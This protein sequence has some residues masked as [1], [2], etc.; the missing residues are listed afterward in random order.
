ME[1]VKVTGR[2]S[3]RVGSNWCAVFIRWTPTADY[4]K[5]TEDVTLIFSLTECKME[6]L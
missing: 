4:T 3:V 1:D 5:T 2:W 6:K